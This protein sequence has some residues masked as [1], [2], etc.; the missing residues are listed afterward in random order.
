MPEEPIIF[1][2]VALTTNLTHEMSDLLNPQRQ[3]ILAEQATTAIF[4]S[5]SNCQ[6]GLKNISFGNLLIKQVVADLQQKLPNL[7]VFATLSP[8]PKFAK[9]LDSELT[10]ASSVVISPDDAEALMRLADPD[11]VA[12]E[13]AA[14]KPALMRAAAAYFFN[15]KRSDGRPVDP[16]GR[17]HLGNGARLERINFL[18]DHSVAG[19]KQSY[20]MMVNYLYD[21]TSIELNH[22]LYADKAKIVASK[23]V[24]R[25]EYTKPVEDSAA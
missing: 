6:A 7:Q 23:Q 15:A 22:E 24:D 9:W 4:Y 11:W 3:P 8:M 17:F 19:L 1:V 2:E 12:A 14:V 13:P 20:G 18:A 10:D 25:P 16:V 21:P 5:I